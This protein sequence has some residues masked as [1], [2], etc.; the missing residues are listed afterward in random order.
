V[1]VGLLTRTDHMRGLLTLAWLVVAL[2]G[3]AAVF[4][5][6]STALSAPTVS[7]DGAYSTGARTATVYGSLETEGLAWMTWAEYARVDGGS[8]RESEWCATGGLAGQANSTLSRV[9]IP[10]SAFDSSPPVSLYGLA[11]G[12]EY[13]TR[14]IAE[15]SGEIAQGALVTFIAGAPHVVLVK[16]ESSDATTVDVE[17]GMETEADVPTRY[18]AEYARSSGGSPSELQWCAS[19]GASGSAQATSVQAREF[20]PYPARGIQVTIAELIADGRYCLRLAA[21]LP[22]GTAHT[23]LLPL[24]AGAPTSTMSFVEPTGPSAMTLVS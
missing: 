18:W 4:A 2:A 17:G 12:A 13:C 21:A 8:A 14:L 19:A 11:A 16:A 9:A 5:A 23:A 1:S 22:S 10:P 3:C 20:G 6:P 7:T 15:E 24:T